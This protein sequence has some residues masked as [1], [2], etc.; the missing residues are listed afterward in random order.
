VTQDLVPDAEAAVKVALGLLAESLGL[1]ARDVIDAFQPWIARAV[2]DA[3]EVRGTL[4]RGTHGGAFVVVVARRDGR[5][6]KIF[7]DR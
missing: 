2:D 7:H 5:L 4:P 1:L 3:W 6:R